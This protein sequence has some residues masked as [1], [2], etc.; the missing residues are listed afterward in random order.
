MTVVRAFL[1]GLAVPAGLVAQS[2]TDPRSPMPERPTVATHAFTVAPGI[3]ELETGVERDHNADRTNSWFAPVYLKLGLAPRAQLGVAANVVGPAEGNAGIGDLTLGVKYRVVDDLPIVGAFAILPSVK[4][5][6]GDAAHGTRTTD[7]SML[8][9][10]SHKWG[11]AA[12]DVNV[13]YTH[14]TGDGSHAP[15]D[16]TLWTVSGGVPLAGAAG[17]AFEVFGYPGTG[18]AT[19]SEPVVAT[20]FGPTFN[21]GDH[22]VADLG[23]IVRLRGPQP[24]ALYA[25]LTYNIGRLW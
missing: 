25:G 19:G 8:F 6:T 11:D 20:L 18:G 4:L 16:A 1:L 21:V 22:A 24:N 13:G 10:S 14:R 15:K 12:L 9:I 23:G 17:L 5:P 3:V 7:A 2:A